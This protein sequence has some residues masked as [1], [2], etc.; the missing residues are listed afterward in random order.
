MHSFDP[1]RRDLAPYGFSCRR[2]VPAV[3]RRA[4]RH[5]EIELNLLREGWLTYLVG[6]KLV[7]VEANRLTAFWAAVPHQIIAHGRQADYF[8]VTVPLGYFLGLR[9]PEKFV[10]ALMHGAMIAGAP[11]PA[12]ELIATRLLDWERDLATPHAAGH[13]ASLLELEAQLRRLAA[14]FPGP[15]VPE[16]PNAK[17]P[18]FLH[19]GALAK[20]ER[21]AQLVADRYA[22]PIEA[23]ELCRAIDPQPKRALKVFQSVFGMNLARFLTDYRVSQAQRLL[24][25]THLRV[26]DISEACG[27]GS[28]GHFNRAFR[29]ACACPPR[30]YRRRHPLAV[31][32]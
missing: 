10:Q 11:E 27:F 8:V 29:L 26:V 12:G 6:G 21:I 24:V 22:E 25:T 4:D 32:S 9:L 23:I 15:G 3:M 20:A 14:A 5:N 7:R 13:R 17:R 2:W 30:E 31:M 18:K 28:L 1:S 19:E 16:A